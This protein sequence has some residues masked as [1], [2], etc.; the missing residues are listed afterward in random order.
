MYSLSP[1]F[2]YGIMF[3]A[4]EVL[5]LQITFWREDLTRDT[6]ANLEIINLLKVVCASNLPLGTCPV[7]ARWLQVERRT[8][9]PTEKGMIRLT[10][11]VCV[12]HSVTFLLANV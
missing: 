7:E 8:M 2:T 3:L 9:L 6:L 10:D 1:Y 5:L 4:Q 12:G 11:R